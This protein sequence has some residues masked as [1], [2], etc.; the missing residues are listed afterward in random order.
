[1][2]SLISVHTHTHTHKQTHTQ[3]GRRGPQWGQWPWT[4]LRNTRD[5]V[6][7]G[8]GGARGGAWGVQKTSACLVRCAQNL[9]EEEKKE[10]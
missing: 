3:A 4:Q 10:I 2:G 8:R 7:V 5:G 1:M 9:N 6:S